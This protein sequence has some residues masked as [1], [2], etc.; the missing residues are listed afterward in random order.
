VSDAERDD[1]LHQLA[2]HASEGRLTLAEL[3][4]RSAQTLRSTTRADLAAVTHDLEPV[5]PPAG[6]A[7]APGRRK[8][9]RWHV[10]LMGGWDKRGRWRIG[11]RLTS[12]AI[13]GGGDLDLRGAEIDDDEVT[14][15]AIAVMGGIGI[16]VPDSIEVEVSGFA[17]MGGNDER[18]S[19]RPPR[20]GAP[21][22]RIQAFALMGGIEVW[23]LPAESAG[24]RLKDARKAAKALERGTG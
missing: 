14:I 11:E 19:T 24:L 17:L 9:T 8:P 4:L 10:S 1:V 12:I 2:H 18:G 16:Y 21:V 13:M 23:R 20:P 15:T 5:R 6:T 22:I 3:E 7:G